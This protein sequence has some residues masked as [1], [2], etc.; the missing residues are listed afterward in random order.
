MNLQDYCMVFD[1]ALPK[2][3]CELIIRTFEHNSDYHERYD[4]DSRPN[5]TQLNI[6]KNKGLS[7]LEALHD[8]ILN[9]SQKIVK[10][11][12]RNTPDC[13]YWPTRYAFEEFRIK[14][15]LNDGNDQFSDHIDATDAE[16]SKR[17]LAFFWYLNDVEEGGET[18]FLNFDLQVTPKAGRLLVFPPIWMYPHRGNAPL[19]NPKYIIGSYLHFV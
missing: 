19:S 12:R 17:F 18:E 13:I 1:N 2:D 11:Y 6:T 7:G 16:S 3:N 5:F 4:N 9:V 10:E 15:Y 8:Y 14:R